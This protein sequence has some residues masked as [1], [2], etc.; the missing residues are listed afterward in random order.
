MMADE[1]LFA[2]KLTTI[3]AVNKRCCPILLPLTL[4]ID[5]NESVQ[6]GRSGSRRL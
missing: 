5:W 1:K 6:A 3:D 2:T 4:Q